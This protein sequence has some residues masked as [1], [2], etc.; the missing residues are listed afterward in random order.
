MAYLLER[1]AERT[2]AVLPSELLE[3]GVI[4]LL[5]RG[6]RNKSLIVVN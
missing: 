3:V 6:K 1:K 4:G 2:V 5:Q